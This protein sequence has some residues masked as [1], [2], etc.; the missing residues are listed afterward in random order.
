MVLLFRVGLLLKEAALCP[1]FRR[2]TGATSKSMDREVE[3]CNFFSLNET[4]LPKIF[5]LPLYISFKSRSGL[6]KTLLV[7]EL[8]KYLILI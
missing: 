2:I 8:E 3:N 5:F 7:W 4:L 1:L 6:K